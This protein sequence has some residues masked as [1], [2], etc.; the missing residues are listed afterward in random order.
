[1]TDEERKHA[2]QVLR[3]LAARATTGPWAT[4]DHI[5]HRGDSPGF[6]HVFEMLEDDPPLASCPLEDDAKY[7]AAAN[8][9]MIVMMLDRIESCELQISHQQR[10]ISTLETALEGK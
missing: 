10:H 9:A 1:M 4:D 8:P 6:W 3:G 2:L 7:I 5:V